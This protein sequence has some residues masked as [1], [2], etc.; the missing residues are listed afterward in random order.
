VY[1]YVVIVSSSQVSCGK[2]TKNLLYVL[3]FIIVQTLKQVKR[4]R[5]LE[6]NTMSFIDHSTRHESAVIG[7]S[8]H[9][10]L[11]PNTFLIVLISFTY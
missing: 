6:I 3:V 4:H 7:M 11:Q 8:L 9:C 5:A 2:M 1:R 10:T